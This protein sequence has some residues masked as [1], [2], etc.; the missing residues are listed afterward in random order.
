MQGDVARHVRLD[1]TF[2]VGGLGCIQIPGDT[3]AWSAARDPGTG[4]IVLTGSAPGVGL[5]IVCLKADGT[6]DTNCLGG[7]GNVVIGGLPGAPAST[8]SPSGLGV[9][10]D[11]KG[12]IVIVGGDGDPLNPAQW[13]FIARLDPTTENYDPTF[14]KGQP[15]YLQTVSGFTAVMTDG[16]LIYAAGASNAPSKTGYD[17]TRRYTEAGD[18]DLSWAGGG[19]YNS[20]NVGD[21]TSK[22]DVPRRI[23]RSTP[24]SGNF[25]VAGSGN[26][27]PAANHYLSGCMIRSGYI[28][29]GATWN[30]SGTLVDGATVQCDGKLVLGG[31]TGASDRSG[32][33]VR[34][35][36]LGNAIDPTFGTGGT[37]AALGGASANTFS[38]VMFDDKTG[39]LVVGLNNNDTAVT[40]LRLIP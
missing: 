21:S 17:E 28:A 26:G 27:H 39:T 35:T 24:Q 3:E 36:A 20:Y 5:P 18:L 38:T 37:V 6:A 4:R 30:P 31:W 40:L 8:A 1:T 9:A 16:V 14:N 7:N 25:A 33:L 19:G 2:G 12:R 10:F 34:L 23:F 13:G 11:A 32:S 15:I 29:P 22:V